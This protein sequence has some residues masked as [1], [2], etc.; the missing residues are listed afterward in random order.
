MEKFMGLKKIFFKNKK[1]ASL[2]ISMSEIVFFYPMEVGLRIISDVKQIEF[3]LLF[4]TFSLEEK[5][6]LLTSNKIPVDLTK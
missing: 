6:F 2:A 1:T 4:N 3:H 5:I